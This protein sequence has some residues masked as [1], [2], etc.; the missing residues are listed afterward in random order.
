MTASQPSC[1]LCATPE[2]CG[3][4]GCAADVEEPSGYVGWELWEYDPSGP[5]RLD[6][7]FTA[8]ELQR[9]VEKMARQDVLA[10]LSQQ[11]AEQVKGGV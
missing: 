5:I 8:Q 10:A 7:E 1:A 11:Q 3:K 2:E 6:G 9:I 4:R